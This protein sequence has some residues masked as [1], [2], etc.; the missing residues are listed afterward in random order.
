M[1]AAIFSLIGPV[2]GPLLAGVAFVIAALVAYFGIK[3]KGVTEERER[4][5][6]AQVKETARVQKQVN[7]AVSKDTEIDLRV[8]DE[9]KAIEENSATP[10][11]SRDDKFRF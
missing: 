9:V 6:A 3:R 7:E 11:P 2:I 1:G 4:Q 10:L 8:Q 5:Q